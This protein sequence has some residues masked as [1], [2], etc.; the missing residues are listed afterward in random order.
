MCEAKHGPP[1]GGVLTAAGGVLLLVFVPA[2]LAAA[3]GALAAFAAVLVAAEA[4]A[5]AVMVAVLVRKLRRPTWRP[6]G[7]VVY[8]PA[9]VRSHYG[10]R[11]TVP[12]TLPA[13]V[14]PAI[15]ARQPQVD[16]LS[17]HDERVRRGLR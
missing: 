5:A 7:A 6:P 12:V 11:I 15:A 1:V 3:A 17:R 2:I 4:A 10:E 9:R 13:Q 16:I 8:R 14:R